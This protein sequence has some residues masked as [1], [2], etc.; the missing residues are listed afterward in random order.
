[1]ATNYTYKG[2]GAA[3]AYEAPGF[4][5]LQKRVDFADMVAN[6]EQVALV[7]APTKGLTSFLGLAGASSDVFQVFKLPAGCL[8]TQMGLSVVTA[9]SLTGTIALGDGA[10]TAGWGAAK[11][12]NAVASQITLVADAFGANNVMGK[13]YVASDTLDLLS[14][15]ALIAEAVIDVWAIVAKVNQV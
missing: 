4:T 11:I 9:D 10:S 12:L 3:L 8:V 15:T 1:M 5:V 2:M 6:P 7:S 13:F 14:A